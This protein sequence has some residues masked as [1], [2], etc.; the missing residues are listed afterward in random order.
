MFKIKTIYTFLNKNLAVNRS[1]HIT[2]KILLRQSGYAMRILFLSKSKI[3]FV[4]IQ[5]NLKRIIIIINTLFKVDTKFT[6]KQHK[7][8]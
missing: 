8:K 3:N 1:I 7:N 2:K 5:K 6:K 4:K